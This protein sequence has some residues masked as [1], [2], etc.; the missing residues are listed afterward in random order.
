MNLAEIKDILATGSKKEVECRALEIRSSEIRNILLD[1]SGKVED[2]GYLLIGVSRQE[3][4]YKI[5]GIL[6]GFN[7]NDIIEQAIN[8]PDLEGT[9]YIID[10]IDRKR[11]CAICVQASI[12]KETKAEEDYLNENIFDD[13]MA[14]CLKLQRNVTF[15]HTSEDQRNDFIRDILETSG[16]SSGYEVRDQTR[17]GKSAVGK[18]SGEVDLLIHRKGRPI[19]IIEALNLTSLDRAYL[20][21]HIDKI[22]TYD[23]AGNRINY[24]LSYVTIADFSG[25]CDKYMKFITNY[26]YP[27]PLKDINTQVQ[28]KY[29]YSDL[30]YLITSHNRNG[31]YTML[32]H[33]CV[34]MLQ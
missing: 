21:K 2:K 26:K 5:V 14:A 30:R 9:E 29:N 25:F 16:C 15:S 11:I 23:T 13:L 33:I 20:S 34:K 22:F 32:Y 10:K 28:D 27:F 6:D 1:L 19:S 24:I 31:Y 17:Q 18:N 7:M 8:V 3:N 12:K 4:A